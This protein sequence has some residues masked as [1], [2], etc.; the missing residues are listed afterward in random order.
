MWL[1]GFQLLYTHRGSQAPPL[2]CVVVV[3]DVVAFFCIL[4]VSYPHFL[5]YYTRIDI[6]LC[7][8][9]LFSCVPQSPPPPFLFNP[10]QQTT[11]NVQHRER[12]RR[13]RK[14]D[15]VHFDRGSLRTTDDG[16]S[17]PWLD[18]SCC[19]FLLLLFLFIPVISPLFLKKN[20]F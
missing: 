16:I 14:R 1:C 12:K 2:F 4:F 8:Y 19:F 15:Q 20:K 13:R 17:L 11:Q 9:F 3:V 18:M 6:S 7:F 5:L 10:Q